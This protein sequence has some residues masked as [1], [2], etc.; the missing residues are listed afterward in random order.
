MK[1]YG[2]LREIDVDAEM[3]FPCFREFELGGRICK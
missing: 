1:T 3:M 2:L